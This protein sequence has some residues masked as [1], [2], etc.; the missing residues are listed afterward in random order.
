MAKERKRL[1]D[2]SLLIK[3]RRYLRQIARLGGAIQFSIN[4]GEGTGE[5]TV[6]MAI[7]RLDDDGEHILELDEITDTEFDERVPTRPR[8]KKK[9]K[10]VNTPRRPE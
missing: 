6:R 7:I 9:K 4:R 8:K 5:E 1:D 10:K 3:F 2:P